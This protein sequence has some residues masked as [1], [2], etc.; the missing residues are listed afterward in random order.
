MSSN[1]LC[2]FSFDCSGDLGEAVLLVTAILSITEKLP[3][4]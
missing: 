3:G 2:S 4:S 1:V